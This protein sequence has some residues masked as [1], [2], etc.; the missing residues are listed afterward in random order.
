MLLILSE[1]RRLNQLLFPRESLEDMVF[2]FPDDFR[3]ERN[4]L[5]CFF[6]SKIWKIFQPDKHRILKKKKKLGNAISEYFPK[7]F[8]IFPILMNYLRYLDEL[9]VSV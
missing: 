1:F 4:E 6:L 7:Y 2:D 8:P 5:I 3:E 9:G